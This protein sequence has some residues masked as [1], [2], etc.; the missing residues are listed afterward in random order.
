MKLISTI[1]LLCCA[2]TVRAEECQLPEL[3]PD[4]LFPS[5]KLE[6]SMGDIVV[7]LN[8][9]RS[10]ITVNNFLRYTLD[11]RYNGTI[12][13]RV[14]ADFVVQGGGYDAEFKKRPVFPPIVNESGNGLGNRQWSIAMA[15]HDDPHSATSQFYF[16]EHTAKRL[17]RKHANLCFWLFRSNQILKDTLIWIAMMLQAA[18]DDALQGI[19]CAIPLTDIFRP[20]DAQAVISGLD[21]G[22]AH[23]LAG[24]QLCIVSEPVR[25]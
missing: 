12:F 22:L 14:V 19:V 16:K 10:P 18:Q 8:R 11:G 21:R 13:H 17:I 1:A 24:E 2:L 23:R 6:T 9:M 4:N 7:E 20:D 15:R 25:H 5:V 3:L